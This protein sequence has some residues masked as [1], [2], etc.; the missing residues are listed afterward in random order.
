M[1]LYLSMKNIIT[2]LFILCS[3]SVFSQIDTIG[4]LTNKP[5]LTLFYS[6][7]KSKFFKV[8]YAEVDGK[9]R[10]GIKH[11][12]IYSFNID[13]TC[14]IYTE[15]SIFSGDWKIINDSLIIEARTIDSPNTAV[16]IIEKYK[17]IKL[18]RKKLVIKTNHYL[19][20]RTLYLK[21]IK[22]KKSF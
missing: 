6:Q 8:I 2:T 19:E 4:L 20:E 16:F 18:T 1:F 17:I 21:L 9:K 5:T 10:A 15:N 13:K 12:Y 14:K 3:F 11:N 22:S 7:P